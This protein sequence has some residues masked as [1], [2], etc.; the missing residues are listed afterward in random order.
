MVLLEMAVNCDF[1]VIE[2]LHDSIKSS[3]CELEA[4]WSLCVCVFESLLPLFDV[5]GSVFTHS[6]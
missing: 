6:Q 1:M 2:Q 5:S 4:Q 3:V